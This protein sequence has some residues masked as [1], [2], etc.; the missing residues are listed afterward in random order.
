MK[1]KPNFV[2]IVLDGARS[3]RLT[4]YGYS[5]DT[6]PFLNKLS[7]K[8][9]V[10]ENAIVNST[11]TLPSVGSLFTGKYPTQHG[12]MNSLNDQIKSLTIAQIL[13]MRGYK[14]LMFSGINWVDSTDLTKGFDQ[15]FDSEKIYLQ[16]S[17]L[18][19]LNL[20]GKTGVVY[21]HL[22]N[23]LRRISNADYANPLASPLRKTFIDKILS[24]RSE[25][26][27][28]FAYLHIPDTHAPYEPP[29][30]YQKFGRRKIFIPGIFGKRFDFW[31]SWFEKAILSRRKKEKSL[32]NEKEWVML[33]N[34]YDNCLFYLD[35]EINKIY[36]QLKS[37]DLL[38]NTVLIITAD[39]GEML[40]E[41]GVISHGY[42]R[43]EVLKVPL[44]VHH[45]SLE[46]RRIKHQIETKNIFY[47]ILE[48]AKGNFKDFCIKN[49]FALGQWKAIPHIQRLIEKMNSSIHTSAEYIRTNQLKYVEFGNK[50]SQLYSLEG[51]EEPMKNPEIKK[52]MKKAIKI[53]RENF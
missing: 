50:E 2:W 42:W 45:P 46:P 40:G 12:M 13:S 52:L 9:V 36:S 38:E 15:V 41:D 20:S 24:N 22:A 21:R 14:T 47:M 32:F 39:H 37:N 27:P 6:T 29:L 34:I 3:D 4:P 10:F 16:N 7:N 17:L 26:S 53:K 33:N 18:P 48:M 11:W 8:S 19:D 31:S 1:T 51:K 23:L 30:K 43:D 44:I 5:R 49:E 28:F 35:S 25:H